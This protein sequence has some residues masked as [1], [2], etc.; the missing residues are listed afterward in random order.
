[1]V[2]KNFIANLNALND[3]ELYILEYVSEKNKEWWENAND[4]D[5][6]NRLSYFRNG[7]CDVYDPKCDYKTPH[8][9][10]IVYN[11]LTRNIYPLIVQTDLY[12][13]RY[14]HLA[15]IVND[16]WFDVYEETIGIILRA[17]AERDC[18]EI[19]EKHEL[20]ECPEVLY[21]EYLDLVVN[22]LD[23][24]DLETIIKF[25]GITDLD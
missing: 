4:N 20:D 10:T 16:L 18:E 11:K 9:Y 5:I 7:I 2:R 22:N 3:T 12:G 25:C 19:C 13:K 8:P 17:F 15:D 23:E 1:M 6:I 21:D 14:E 24:N